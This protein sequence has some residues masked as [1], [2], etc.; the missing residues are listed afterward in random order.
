MRSY[1]S[2]DIFLGR[3]PVIDRSQATIGYQLLFRTSQDNAAIIVSSVA[4]TADVICNSFAELGISAAL[5]ERKAFIKID[6]SFL[7]DDVLELLVRSHVVFGLDCRALEHEGVVD[8]CRQLSGEGLEF[9]VSGVVDVTD[10]LRRMAGIASY[11]KVDVSRCESTRLA[12]RLVGL[13]PNLMASKVETVETMER[14]RDAGYTHFQGNYFSRPVIIEG[15][16]LESSTQ[17]LVH[18]IGLLQQDAESDVLDKAFRREPGLTV[19]LLRLTNSVGVG[20]TCKVSSIRQAIAVLGRRQLLRWLQLLLF[21]SGA[22]RSPLSNNPLMQ[23]AA[24]RAHLMESLAQ[25]CF[26][27]KRELVEAAFLCGLMSLVPAA[28]GVSMTDVLSS[29][30][31]S[32]EVRRA[33]SQREGDLGVLLELVER[34]DD[35]D[36]EATAVA[37]RRLGG[38]LDFNFLGHAL[39]E[40]IGWVQSLLEAPQ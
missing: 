14:C 10:G 35:N 12:T 32:P 2:S 20:L 3:Q 40:A 37:M 34:Y 1:S 24:L 39:S 9:M 33:L 16:K 15:R 21:S 29:V 38:D 8:R 4:A 36:M 6:H 5:G 31:V 27:E 7:H 23:L 19:N 22:N 26:L 13:A 25:K 28:L 30:A 11:V 18:L 17:G